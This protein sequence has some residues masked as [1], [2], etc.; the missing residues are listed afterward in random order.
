MPEFRDSGVD[1]WIILKSHVINVLAH[2]N[3]RVKS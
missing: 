3:K 2:Y 1:N